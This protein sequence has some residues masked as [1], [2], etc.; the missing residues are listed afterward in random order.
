MLWC[1]CLSI[2]I[3]GL[4]GLLEDRSLLLLSS[5]LGVINGERAKLC[6]AFQIDKQCT[7]FSSDQFRSVCGIMIIYV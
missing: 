3:L 2:N 1:L 5:E 7:S 4:V 6:G